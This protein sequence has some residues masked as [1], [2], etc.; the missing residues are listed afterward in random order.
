M[1]QGM[2]VLGHSDRADLEHPQGL[3]LTGPWRLQT[4]AATSYPPSFLRAGL[5]LR[6]LSSKDSGE[7]YTQT[8]WLQILT[9]SH[10][11]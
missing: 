7:F 2:D 11:G 3:S 6:V 10:S 4:V 1:T 5:E 9:L 8:V